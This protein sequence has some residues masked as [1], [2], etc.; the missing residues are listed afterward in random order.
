M[1][2]LHIIDFNDL[3]LTRNFRCLQ[4]NTVEYRFQLTND[5]GT[6]RDVSDCTFTLYLQELD[7]TA[8]DDFPDEVTPDESEDATDGEMHMRVGDGVTTELDQAPYYYALECE[9]PEENADFPAGAK[10]V[11]LAGIIDISATLTRA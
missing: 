1:A 2:D 3:P 6:G 7:G 10:K 11:L 5:A 8:I 4:G 9:W